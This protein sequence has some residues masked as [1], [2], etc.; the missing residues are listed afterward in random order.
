MPFD[1]TIVITDGTVG[2]GLKPARIIAAPVVVRTIAALVATRT[3][4][5]S[6]IGSFVCQAMCP[7]PD[8][9]TMQLAQLICSG[10]GIREDADRAALCSLLFLC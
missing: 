4:A 1:Y 7:H 8:T 2:A 5:A 9:A 10:I 6:T 3:I